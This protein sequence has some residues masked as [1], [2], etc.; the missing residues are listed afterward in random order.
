LSTFIPYPTLFRSYTP[1]STHRFK[2]TL[3][4]RTILVTS[5]SESFVRP[6]SNNPLT[7]SLRATLL[8]ASELYP[9][10][11]DKATNRPPHP[12]PRHSNLW[13]SAASPGVPHRHGPP[14]FDSTPT[15]RRRSVIP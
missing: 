4:C 5:K 12:S 7:C 9:A 13:A 1:L 6:T 10:F 15:G 3:V 8:Y 14:L 2:A 11:A